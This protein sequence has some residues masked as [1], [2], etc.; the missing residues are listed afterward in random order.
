MNDRLDPEI[1]ELLRAE[2]DRGGAPADARARVFERVQAAIVV[3][4]PLAPL[5]P[6]T[7]GNAGAIGSG[8]RAW[9]VAVA[10]T[11]AGVGATLASRRTAAPE[12][13]SAPPATA[14]VSAPP[15]ASPAVPSPA[16]SLAPS[17]A[18]PEAAPV[19]SA[20][21]SRTPLPAARPRAASG[22]TLDVERAIL[23]R[24]RRDLLARDTHASLLEVETHARRFPS[25]VLAEERDALRIEAL[26]AAGRSDEARVRGSAFRAAHPGSLLLPAVNDALDA[27]P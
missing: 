5:T 15:P 18:T 11:A 27:S 6:S 17:A 22:D 19:P 3:P 25:G 10:I 7:A 12:V 4:P 16:P 26:A 13:H 9:L 24:A 2:R 1:A 14:V 8:L 20:D 21:T 23:D